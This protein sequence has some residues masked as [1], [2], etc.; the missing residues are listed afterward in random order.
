MGRKILLPFLMLLVSSVVSFAAGELAYR[1]YLFGVGEKAFTFSI[2]EKTRNLIR[3]AYPVELNRRLGWIPSAKYNGTKNIFNSRLTV[4]DDR[5]RSNGDS[6][7]L[8]DDCTIVAVGDSFTF[9][10]EVSD[11]DTWPAHLERNLRC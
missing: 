5:T 1:I 9:G 3:N 8:R 4:L 10:D 2:G 11:H 7:P 6:G